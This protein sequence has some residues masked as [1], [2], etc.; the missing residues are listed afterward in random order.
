MRA[1]TV[2]WSDRGIAAIGTEGDL[3]GGGRVRRAAA[4]AGTLAVL[5]LVS[6]C[7]STAHTQS[8]QGT[9]AVTV[10]SSTNLVTTPPPTTPPTASTQ[11]AQSIGSAGSALACT[12]ADLSARQTRSGSEMSQPFSTVTL[13]NTSAGPCAL[14]GYPTITT[15]AGTSDTAPGGSP[16]PVRAVPITVHDGGIYEV[17]DPGPSQVTLASG[18]TAWF[19]I[20]T[21]TALDPPIVRLTQV[22]LSLPGPGTPL[23]GVT[24]PVTLDATA[25]TGH[26]IG[27]TVTAFA[28]GTSHLG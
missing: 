6:G 14:N 11:P 28:A 2:W 27:I 26:P 1:T 16:G 23:S 8:A 21:L 17:P 13:T 3:V 10:Q 19:A 7:S 12:A 20:G 4:V 22:S 5:G 9:S 15:A 25:R 24:I 18:G